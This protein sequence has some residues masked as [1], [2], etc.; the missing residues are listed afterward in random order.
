MPSNTD[1]RSKEK[2]LESKEKKEFPPGK[3]KCQKC[4]VW[5]LGEMGKICEDCLLRMKESRKVKE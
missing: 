5:G 1:L 3:W 2:P 4:Q